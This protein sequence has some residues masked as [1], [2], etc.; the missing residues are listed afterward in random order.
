MS[1]RKLLYDREELGVGW[2]LPGDL[3]AEENEG[4][5]HFSST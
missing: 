2:K 5:I 1:Q 3:I 4:G